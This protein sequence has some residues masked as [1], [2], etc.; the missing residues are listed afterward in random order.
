MSLSRQW[1]VTVWAADGSH[2]IPLIGSDVI[3]ALMKVYN[4]SVQKNADLVK[5]IDA[6][7]CVFSGKQLF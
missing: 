5:C 1:L 4:Q 7:E 6:Q 3:F 2:G